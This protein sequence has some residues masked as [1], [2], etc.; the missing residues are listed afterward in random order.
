MQTLIVEIESTAKAKE[1]SSILSSINFVKK[2]STI[3]KPKAMLEALQ[4]HEDMKR[5][6]LKRKNKAIAKYL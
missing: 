4:E 5:A 2:V 3:R 6:I 1:L